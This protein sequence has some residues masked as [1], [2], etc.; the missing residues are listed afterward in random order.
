[1]PSR[2]QVKLVPWY[3]VDYTFI[4]TS[5]LPNASQCT[6]RHDLT[7][8][9]SRSRAC[10]ES[11][12]SC[13]LLSSRATASQLLLSGARPLRALSGVLSCLSRYTCSTLH[14]L[15]TDRSVPACHSKFW[16]HTHWTFIRSNHAQNSSATQPFSLSSCAHFA[17]MS[18]IIIP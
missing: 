1:M 5:M 4:L 12:R 13:F 15:S 7:S 3:P 2:L 18:T 14:V 11:M 17:D 8:P 16:Q 9:G 10:R 6:C